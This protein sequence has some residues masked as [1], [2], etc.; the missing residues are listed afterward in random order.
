[1]LAELR[2]EREQIVEA[3]IAIERLAAGTHGKRQGRPPKWMS[4]ANAETAAATEP[5]KDT[6]SKRRWP[7]TN[8]GG[9]ESTLGGKE[10][11]SELSRVVDV[12]ASGPAPDSSY[13][14]WKTQ[15]KAGC[16][17]V[18]RQGRYKPRP[19]FFRRL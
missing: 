5:R 14:P 19:R 3:I 8:G 18:H 16:L 12:M 9:S 6:D 11:P 13:D 7:E 1:M 17:G 2:A 15:K 4:G 10:G